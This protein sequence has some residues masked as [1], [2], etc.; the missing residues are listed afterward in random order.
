MPILKAKAPIAVIAT[1]V[2]GPVDRGLIVAVGRGQEARVARGQ[3]GRAAMKA[4]RV[5]R[6]RIVLVGIVPS[7][8]T[9]R[10]KAA[11]VAVAMIVDRAGKIVP[12]LRRRSRFR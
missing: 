7:A 3:A 4:G 10:R 6:A 11:P 9:V 1:T 12:R 8:E 5:D 2:A